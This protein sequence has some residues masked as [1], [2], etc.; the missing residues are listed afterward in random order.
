MIKL[1]EVTIRQ[2]DF[3]LEMLNLSIPAG[4][5]AV[6]MGP[7]GCGKTTVMETICG[8]RRTSSG[9]ISVDGRNV[10]HCDPAARGIG[11]V[12][13]DQILF[14]TMR[15][16]KQIGYGL[17]VRKAG[18]EN[19]RKRVAELAQL[20]E[21]EH[22][23]NRFPGGLSG[24][25]K[26]RIALAR[27]L[28]FRP[29]LLCLDEPLSALDDETRKRIAGLLKTIHEQEAVTVLHITHNSQDALKIGTKVF[30]FDDGK[31]IES[32]ATV[33]QFRAQDSMN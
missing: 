4:E 8:L 21:I 2:D 5:Y 30:V 6:L 10:T 24:G 33:D 27:A 11:Y 16:D 13:Q 3:A 28:S 12:P 9:T 18:K 29:R 32:K 25:E 26:Q 31:I 20:V 15:I 19:V 23:L 22:L 17:L 1:E 7:T 14:P